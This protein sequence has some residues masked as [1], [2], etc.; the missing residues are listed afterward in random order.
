MGKCIMKG[1]RM[2]GRTSRTNDPFQTVFFLIHRYSIDNG[3]WTSCD[4][5]HNKCIYLWS[6]SPS[7]YGN[8]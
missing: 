6:T 5:L 2:T 3:I 1:M 7:C 4:I 8:G